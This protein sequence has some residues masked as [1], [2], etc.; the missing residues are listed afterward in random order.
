MSSYEE[1]YLVPKNQFLPQYN[2]CCKSHQQVLD[3]INKITNKTTLHI[4]KKKSQ[5]DN[6]SSNT[7]DNISI[8]DNTLQENNDENKNSDDYN[9]IVTDISYKKPIL[10][11]TDNTYNK[12]DI[13]SGLTQ[14]ILT[15]DKSIQTNKTIED[16]KSTQTNQIIDNEDDDDNDDDD[17]DKIEE[18]KTENRTNIAKS[19]LLNLEQELDIMKKKD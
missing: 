12:P 6:I 1:M 8:N 3:K 18:N 7:T 11:D 10:N 17:D 9:S 16:N 14:P 15:D 4:D 19:V 5:S 13:E 2:R